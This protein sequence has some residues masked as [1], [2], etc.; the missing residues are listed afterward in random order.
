MIYPDIQ[1]ERLILSF[2]N[3]DLEAHYEKIYQMYNQPAVVSRIG[4]NVHSYA[5]VD[6]RLKKH[7]VPT[8][9]CHKSPPPEYSAV[10]C[11]AKDSG[12]FVGMIALFL[13]GEDKT[14]V[15]NMQLGWTILTEHGGR[16][17]ATE[18]ATA[19]ITFCDQVLGPERIA[20]LVSMDNIASRRV[21]EKAGGTIR[22]NKAE[23]YDERELIEYEWVFQSPN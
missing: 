11:H 5:D 6:D 9:I 18:A 10:I 19:V 16:G 15:W 22:E 7:A 12:E 17:Y 21:A 3:P 20:A 2:F 13:R 1:T 4:K 14:S 8:G 23:R